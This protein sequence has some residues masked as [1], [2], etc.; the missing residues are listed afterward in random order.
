MTARATSEELDVS[1][2]P[3][4]ADLQLLQG[5]R[6]RQPQP[7]QHPPGDPRAFH[8]AP[9]R[10]WVAIV[11]GRAT[12]GLGDGSTHDFQTGDMVLF[13]DVT[14]H[15]HTIN[16]PEPSHPLCDAAAQPVKSGKAHKYNS[17]RHNTPPQQ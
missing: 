10:Q 2:H 9:Q 6:L 4:L 1:Q 8:N 3:E 11:Q 16:W 14:G 5:L 17:A 15:G 7:Q 13:E 12:V